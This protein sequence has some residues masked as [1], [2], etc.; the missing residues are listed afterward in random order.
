[1]ADVL[2]MPPRPRQKGRRRERPIEGAPLAAVIDGVAF[3]D[4]TK[5]TYAELTAYIDRLAYHLLMAGRTVRDLSQASE[6]Y[7]E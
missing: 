7:R 1:V 3:R 2:H 5:P 6:A 4:P